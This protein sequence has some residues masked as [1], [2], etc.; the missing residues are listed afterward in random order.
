MAKLTDRRKTEKNYTGSSPWQIR[1][2]DDNDKQRSEQFTRKADAETRLTEITTAKQLGRLDVLDAGKVTLRDRGKQYI[3]LNPQAWSAAT[4]YGYRKL[5]NAHVHD[6][7][8]AATQLRSIRASHV[9]QWK[10]DAVASKVPEG[11]I[12]KALGLISQVL[13]HAALDDVIPSNP[14]RSVKRP[15][16]ARRGDIIV[17]APEGVEAIRRKLDRR[18]AA[19]VSVLAYAGLRPEELRALRWR[20]VGAKALR[21]EYAL[22][23]DGSE[24]EIKGQG[25]Q[26]RSVPICTALASDLTSYRDGAPDQ[27]L[28]FP[29]VPTGRTNRGADGPML[30]EDWARWRSGPFKAAREAAGARITRPYDLRHSIASLWLRERVDP[31]TVARRLGHS[32]AVLYGTYA[33]VM[34]DL[35]DDDARTTDEMIAEA[36]KTAR[37]SRRKTPRKAA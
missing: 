16:G 34:D 8:L 12:R 19:I 20:H 27:A 6:T 29:F 24:A 28:I 26:R 32:V 3:T 7:D 23:A 9:Q 2:R 18:D 35:E 1:Y 10:V 36:R 22:L 4:E 31:V 14:A 25:G 11:S 33:H 30:K 5:W 17:T 15:S 37:K 13:D 21:V